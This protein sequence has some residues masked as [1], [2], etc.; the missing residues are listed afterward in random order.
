[1]PAETPAAVTNHPFV[2]APHRT[3]LRLALPVLL[4]LTAEPLTGLVDTA[5]VASLG[6]V[7]LAGLGVGTAAL[8]SIFW[9]FNFLGIGSQS[10]VAQALGRDDPARARQMSGLALLLATG[11]GLAIIGLGWLSAGWVADALGA[12]GPVRADAIRY[13]HMRLI[14]APAVLLMVAAFGILRGLQDMRTPLWVALAVNGL[15]IALDGPFIYGWGPFPA[16]G[17]GG[18]GLASSLSQWVG[19]AW[20]I[21]AIYRRLGR[22]HRLRWGDAARLLQ[23]GGDI[24]IRTGLITFFLLLTTRAATLIGPD[25]GAAHQAIRQI[26]IFTALFL[27]AFAITGQSLV[28]Y[29]MGAGWPAQARRVAAMVCGWSFATGVGLGLS[30]WL[31]RS[32]VMAVLLP[33]SAIAIFLPAWAINAAAQPLNALAFATD[34]LLW[35]VSDYKYLRNAMIAATGCGML[36]LFFV[37][38]TNPHALTWIWVVTIIVVGIRALLGMLRIWG[39]S[40]IQHRPI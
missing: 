10:E 34:G 4:S 31:G 3:L 28:G 8:S 7:A 37:D 32:A 30:M 9:V 18:A 36:L 38:K 19:V 6:A 25:G 12:G 14:G 5:F 17:V 16:L 39:P 24:F 33:P 22:P 21:W 27:D 20:V 11:I 1:V 15:N 26:Y 40:E 13:I 23:I 29:F 35:G 2:R